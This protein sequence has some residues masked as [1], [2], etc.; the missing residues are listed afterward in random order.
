[1]MMMMIIIMC[2]F[3]PAGFVSQAAGHSITSD[4]KWHHFL[5]VHSVCFIHLNK[6]RFSFR[7][8]MEDQEL[9][10]PSQDVT[11]SF[12]CVCYKKVFHTLF[13]YGFYS[14]AVVSRTDFCSTRALSFS[15][16]NQFRGTHSADLNTQHIF[17]SAGPVRIQS[18]SHCARISQ[19]LLD[20]TE[21]QW[22]QRLSSILWNKMGSY[23]DFTSTFWSSLIYIQCSVC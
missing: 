4:S 22:I 9:P 21:M 19:G 7:L 23:F 2:V 17:L 1:M 13:I 12:I 10:S 5:L 11:R 15:S 8:W 6:S 16:V 18:L 14:S 3:D 20:L